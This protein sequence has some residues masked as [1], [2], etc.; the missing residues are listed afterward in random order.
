M[1]GEVLVRPPCFESWKSEPRSRISAWP[2]ARSFL[3]KVLCFRAVT[4]R[5]FV[6]DQPY[7]N[8][9]RGA[10]VFYS[11]VDSDRLLRIQEGSPDFHRSFFTFPELPLVFVGCRQAVQLFYLRRSR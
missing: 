1:E 2:L 8:T 6:I 3:S 10:R 9:L 11:A 4:F 5:W 7:N